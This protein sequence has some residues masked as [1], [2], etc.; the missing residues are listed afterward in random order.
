M[1]ADL[2]PTANDREWT[3]ILRSTQIHEGWVND[4]LPILDAVLWRLE[5]LKSV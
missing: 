4:W 1:G 5:T 2:K 3:R